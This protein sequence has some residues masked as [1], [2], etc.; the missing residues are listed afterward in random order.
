MRYFL[1]HNSVDI[2]HYGE[3][4]DSQV[5]STG[6]PNLEYFNSLDELKDRLS[7]FGVVCNENNCPK[8]LDNLLDNLLDDI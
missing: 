3:L 8:D 4:N 1:A 6:Q 7:F 5:V 2:F